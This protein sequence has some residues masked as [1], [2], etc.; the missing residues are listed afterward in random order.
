MKIN[1]IQYPFNLT[2]LS[3]QNFLSMYKRKNE[4]VSHLILYFMKY[5]CHEL[6]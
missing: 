6:K 4:I 3:K 2:K 5:I 1:I